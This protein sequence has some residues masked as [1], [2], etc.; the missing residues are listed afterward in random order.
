M[1]TALK[2]TAGRQAPVFAYRDFTYANLA[3]GVAKAIIE[4]PA[5]A[6]VIGG[7][8][9]ITDSWDSSTSDSFVVGDA[10]ADEYLGAT[11]GQAEA[12]T[13][14]VP[15]GFVQTAPAYVTVT[16]TGVGDAPTAGA[17][18]V[19]VKYY[20]RGRAQFAQGLDA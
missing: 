3:T 17:A 19:E 8:L 4:L 11:D 5:G 14:L 13:E 12:R 1:T 9:T 20:V 16:W 2:L 7:A 10:D 15:T 18:T 6:V